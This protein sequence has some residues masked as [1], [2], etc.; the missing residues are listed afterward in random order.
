ML[1]WHRP[2]ALCHARKAMRDRLAFKRGRCIAP[3]AAPACPPAVSH[4]CH[5]LLL[6]DGPSGFAKQGQKYRACPRRLVLRAQEDVRLIQLACSRALPTRY[7]ALRDLR[8][9]ASLCVNSTLTA[10]GECVI[11]GTARGRRRR[12]HEMRMRP[13]FVDVARR[14]TDV[15]RRRQ[16][17]GPSSLDAADVFTTR[18]GL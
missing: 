17:S 2:F 6:T 18:E 15:L 8:V 3:L 4:G 1:S 14:I 13:P 12:E 11:P 10:G 16:A 7:L 5:A 9:V